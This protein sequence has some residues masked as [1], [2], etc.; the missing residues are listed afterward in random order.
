MTRPAAAAQPP[1]PRR[2]GGAVGA[3]LATALLVAAMAWGG[4]GIAAA[5]VRAEGLAM[6]GDL[7]NHPGTDRG[8]HGGADWGD[9]SHGAVEDGPVTVEDDLGLDD[10]FADPDADLVGP[11]DGGALTGP[12]GAEDEGAPSTA[13]AAPAPRDG[14]GGQARRSM[15]PAPTPAADAAA[16]PA[17]PDTGQARASRVLV[18]LFTS[19]GCSA[20]PPAEALLGDLARRDDVLAVS[21]HVDYWDY[22]GWPDPFAKPA[23]TSRQRAYARRDGTRTVFTPQIVVGGVAGATAPRPAQVSREIARLSDDLSVAGHVVTAAGRHRVTLLSDHALRVPADVIVARL[24]RQVETEIRSG[25]NIGRSLRHVNVA[26][27][28]D[29]VAQWSGEKPLLLDIATEASA[30]RGEIVAV[31]VQERLKGPGGRNLPGA[32][33]GAIQVTD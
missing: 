25:E 30:R 11:R 22:L 8:R 32:V 4:V 5:P 15:I 16:A 10:D 14:R 1:V 27:D 3:R 31:I 17:A 13:P 21:F 20:C 24:D 23:F 7:S 18:E 2:P 33:L 12:D 6:N 19:E 26:R 9:D 29:L 28:W